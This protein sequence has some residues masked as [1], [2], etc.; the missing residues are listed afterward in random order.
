MREVDVPSGRQAGMPT[1]SAMQCIV[2]ERSIAQHALHIAQRGGAAQ[3]AGA[4]LQS[5]A[6]PP[7]RPPLL[8]KP[9]P[10]CQDECST[11]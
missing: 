8:Q 10:S 6:P 9:P 5:K 11:L 1:D 3:L 2:V 4:T 7:S